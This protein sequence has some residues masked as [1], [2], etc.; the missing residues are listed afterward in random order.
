[1]KRSWR[2]LVAAIILAATIAAF[3]AYFRSHPAV[4]HQLRHTSPVLLI[5]LLI[6]Y[7]GTIAA[8]AM[9]TL[10]SLRICKIKLETSES[11]LLTAYTAVVNFFG[12]LQ[13][14]PAFRGVYLKAKHGLNLKDYTLV[15]L[16]Y[17]GFWGIYSGL[18]LI[19][20]ILGW[21]LIPLV[22]LVAIILYKEYRTPRITKRFR[23]LNLRPIL[24]LAIATFLQ[25]AIVCVIYYSELKSIA[26]ATHFSQAV[27]YTGAANL[28]LF[29]SLTPAA[30]G[31]R[32]S[33][34]LFSRQLHH[35]SSNTI[36]TASILDRSVYVVFLLLL[37][38]FIFSTHASRRLQASR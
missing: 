17:L 34:L 36:V 29:V 37:A 8:L 19:S 16:L 28:A 33:F 31:F 11:L 5:W 23:H 27:I 14:G 13:S 38:V 1:M 9:T 26:P 32:E 21:W 6:L 12:P 7:A 30:I 10:A 24:F 25:T 4:G 3:V 15:T 20:G 2:P 35:I 22:V 18:F